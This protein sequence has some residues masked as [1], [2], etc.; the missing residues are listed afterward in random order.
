MLLF[1]DMQLRIGM[2]SMA[3]SDFNGIH[4]YCEL[5]L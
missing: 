5:T 1:V 3:T 2:V 4:A